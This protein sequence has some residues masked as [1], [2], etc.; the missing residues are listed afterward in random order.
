MTTQWGSQR[1]DARRTAC[2]M[3][4]AAVAGDQ[5]RVEALWRPLDADGRA[6]VVWSLAARWRQLM[7]RAA[8]RVPASARGQHFLSLLHTLGRHCCDPVRDFAFGAVAALDMELSAPS[9][10]ACTRL[11]AETFCQAQLRFADAVGWPRQHLAICRDPA[12]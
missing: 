1:S 8:S 6:T 4:A 12:T 9:C 3:T 2:L 11:A 7:H 5:A 10:R